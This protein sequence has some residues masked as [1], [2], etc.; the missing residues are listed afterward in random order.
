MRQAFVLKLGPQTEAASRH[1]EGTIEEVDT[2]RELR[3]KATEELLEFLAER[4][5]KSQ[6]RAREP[7][8][9]RE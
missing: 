8:D 1:F 6:K 5:E 9:L 7:D 3:F 4:F 2:G